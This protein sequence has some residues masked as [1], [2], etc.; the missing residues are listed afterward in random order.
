MGPTGDAAT[1]RFSRLDCRR[2]ASPAREPELGPAAARSRAGQPA[3]VGIRGAR[4]VM[5]R[6][7][8]CATRSTTRARGA[9]SASGIDL[10]LGPARPRARGGVFA[11]MGS[12]ACAAA[13]CGRR[14]ARSTGR[15]R[16]GL[17]CARCASRTADRCATSGSAARGGRS[18]GRSAGPGVGTAVGAALVGAAWAASTVVG[19]AGGRRSSACELVGRARRA[20]R[21]AAGCIVGR[22]CRRSRVSIV[23]RALVGGARRPRSLERV[24]RGG[25]AGAA[26]LGRAQGR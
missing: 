3:D 23:A 1:T 18:S 9:S 15:A 12:T 16:A 24:A 19:S 7:G 11:R 5:G 14:A 10:S 6:A 25:T 26:F 13:A 2:H 8:R 4:A 21:R 20:R 22:S 17:G